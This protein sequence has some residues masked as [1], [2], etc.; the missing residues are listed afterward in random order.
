MFA[1]TQ[2]A[3]AKSK[4]SSQRSPPSMRTELLCYLRVEGG[5]RASS[6]LRITQIVVLRETVHPPCLA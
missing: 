2:S 6:W 4:H 3:A 5:L 1:T